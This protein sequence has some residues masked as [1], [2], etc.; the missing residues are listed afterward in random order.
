MVYSDPLCGGAYGFQH[1]R[2]GIMTLLGLAAIPLC[3][4][5][6]L[7]VGELARGRDWHPFLLILPTAAY[8]A[9]VQS[10]ELDAEGLAKAYLMFTYAL[11]FFY[12]ALIFVTARRAAGPADIRDSSCP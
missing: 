11:L 8:V 5:R 1:C 3:L 4:L 6:V 12:A 7:V 2:G 9:Y 10:S